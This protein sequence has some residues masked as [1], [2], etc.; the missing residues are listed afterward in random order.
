LSV[1][2]HWQSGRAGIC[3][4]RKVS[5]VIRSHMESCPLDQAGYVKMGVW[6]EDEGERGCLSLPG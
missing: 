5:K 4:K 2:F 3:G 6:R 1:P